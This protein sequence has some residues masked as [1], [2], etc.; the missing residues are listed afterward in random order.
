MPAAEPPGSD[1]SLSEIT[2]LF[3]PVAGEA[4]L[5]LAVSGG[6]DSTALMHLAH[7]WGATRDSP[8]RL[9]VLTVDHGLRAESAAEAATVARWAKELGLRHATLQWTG[10]KPWTGLQALAREARYRLMTGWCAEHG[11]KT[12]I[13]AHTIDDQAE[14]VLMRLKRGA[15]VEGLGGMEPVSE[16]D[17]VVLFRPLLG[18]RRERLRDLLRSIRRSWIDDPSNEDE[19][20]E[21]IGMRRALA[22]AG[23]AAESL[24]LTARRARRAFDAILDASRTF[25]EASVIHHEEGYGEI[26]RDRWLAAP[27][28]I[29]LRAVSS[30]VSR[31]G[32]RSFTPLSQLEMLAEWLDFGEG[33]A[34][35]LGGCRIERSKSS[36]RFGREPGR[37]D[38]SPVPVSERLKW[39]G[40]FDIV[41]HGRS[42]GLA[43]IPAGVARD[44]KRRP[45]LPAFVQAGL[46]AI[47]LDGE[48]AAVPH[49]GLR[50]EAAPPHLMVT[51]VFDARPWF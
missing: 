40:R 27:A 15:G 32:D 39:D 14:T 11:V 24:A 9:T 22:E 45:A 18:E 48:L 35:T 31:Y 44:L 12:L 8:P 5:A 49:L 38:P 1:F 20:F 30:L 25:L 36:V 17:G 6:S 29:K 46:P 41:V 7:R 43:V 19:K 47:L 13:L 21:R 33:R 37:I 50:T 23:I 2:R 42:T 34:R 10:A 51:A 3:E 16:R 4:S 28:E 26:A